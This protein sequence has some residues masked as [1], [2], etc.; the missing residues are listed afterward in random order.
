MI[1][2]HSELLAPLRDDELRREA[3]RAALADLVPRAQRPS[4][5]STVALWLGGFLI[6]AGCRID[7]AGRRHAPGGTMTFLPAPC[8]QNT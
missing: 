3:Q 5:L 4:R 8:G 1:S 6:D 2:M 7:A